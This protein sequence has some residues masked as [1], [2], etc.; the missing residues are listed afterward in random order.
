MRRLS[1][2]TLALFTLFATMATALAEEEP[3]DIIAPLLDFFQ[4]PENQEFIARFTKDPVE[5]KS[6]IMDPTGDFY[7][8]TGQTPGF[9]PDYIDITDA[10]TVDFCQD[11]SISS[12]PR[13]RTGSGRP[14]APWRSSLPTTRPFTPS[15]AR[16]L[17]TAPS[18]RAAPT[19]LG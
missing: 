13:M 15:S 4:A 1:L 7:H 3:N 9:T 6:T 2:V 10:W 12:P 11:R 19:S 14:P 17:R 5:G 16:C 18:S 8:S